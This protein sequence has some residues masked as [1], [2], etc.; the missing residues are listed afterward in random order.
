[1][2]EIREFEEE[3]TSNKISQSSINETM[4]VIRKRMQH[5]SGEECERACIDLV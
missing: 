1:M 2:R 4:E 3:A 5:L